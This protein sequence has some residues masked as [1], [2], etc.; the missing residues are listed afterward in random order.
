[1]AG[2]THRSEIPKLSRNIT[3]DC[4][5]QASHCLQCYFAIFLN[6][7]VRN[8][9]AVAAGFSSS[10]TASLAVNNQPTSPACSPRSAANLQDDRAGL[11]SL[12]FSSQMASGKTRRA[13]SRSLHRKLFLLHGP[14]SPAFIANQY[15]RQALA[16]D[17]MQK[18]LEELRESNALKMGILIRHHQ[19]LSAQL[20][21]LISVMDLETE[22]E[23]EDN[24]FLD[25]DH[26]M[27]D[28]DEQ[29]Q[30]LIPR[31]RAERYPSLESMEDPYA[32]S[33]ESQIEAAVIGDMPVRGKPPGV[34]RTM[35]SVQQSS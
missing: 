1:M 33:V 20:E 26:W 9:V 23:M 32:P 21:K 31:N 30:N 29:S 28:P 10:S 3:A 17:K 14:A 19:V 22:I 12:N 11:P 34:S 27:L 5:R 35:Y 25:S 7:L 18:S 13:A 6:P 8:S 24:S 4:P 16:M 15:R 2:R